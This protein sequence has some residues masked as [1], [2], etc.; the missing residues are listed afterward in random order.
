MP[1]IKQIH[2]TMVCDVNEVNDKVLNDD[3]GDLIHFLTTQRASL[4]FS[5]DISQ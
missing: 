3:H 5:F 4:M 2:V 1:Q